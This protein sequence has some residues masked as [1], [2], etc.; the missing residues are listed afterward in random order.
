MAN[1]PLVYQLEIAGHV[2]PAREVRGREAMSDPFRF[3][4]QCYLPEHAKLDP[5][6]VVKSEV[7]LV[8]MREGAMRQVTAL[9][10]DAFVLDAVAGQ[11]ELTV[12]LEPRFALL[13]YKSNIKIFRDKGVQ[14]IVSEVLDESGVAHEWRLSSGYPVRP[15][16][17]QH[18]ETDRH[19]VARM[20]EEE[21]IFYF[22]TEQGVM[23]L[24]DSPAAYDDVGAVPFL[25]AG[26]MDRNDEGVAAM[27]PTAAASVGQVTLRDW[28]SDTPS[29]NMDV[30]ASGPTPAGPEFYDFPGEYLEPGEGQRLA[31]LMADAYEC[32]ANGFAGTSYVGA[33][34]PGRTF[35]LDHPPAGVPEGR[36][37]LTAVE[38]DWHRE[39][40]GF[41]VTFDAL[42]GARTFRPP[43]SHPEPILPNPVTGIVTGP[44]GE[45]DIYTDER[46]RVKVHFHWDRLLP[47]DGECSDWVPVLQDNTGESVA[48]P[49]IGWEVLVHY[50]EGDPDR[51]VVLGRVY[52]AEDQ[53]PAL[54]PRDKT[55]TSLKSY[56]SPTRDGI[57]MIEF[58]DLAGREYVYTHAEKD[59]NIV[60][61]NDK[62]EDILVSEKTKVNHDETIQI[63]NNTTIKIDRHTTT[64]VRAN[65]T[66]SVGGNQSLDSGANDNNTIEGNRALSVGGSYHRRLGQIETTQV[67]QTLTE[68]VGGAILETSLSTNGNIGGLVYA[69]TVGGAI[70]EIAGKQK[71]ESAAKA[72]VE[73]IGGVV[74]SSVDG[75]WKTEVG[76][77][78][79]TNVGAIKNVTAAKEL[80]LTGKEKF[81]AVSAI[82]QYQS[83]QEL[84]FKVGETELCMKDGLIKINAPETVAMKI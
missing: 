67:S 83:E 57:N 47:C 25:N 22:F 68:Q 63:G 42:D 46:G 19:F 20:L 17:V 82:G 14:T 2:L 8:L 13:R 12:V 48:H 45:D 65:Q 70:V 55:R 15:Y 7:Q 58:Q 56:S 18:R 35:D 29:L 39:Q 59:Q 81:S 32:Q 74:F 75:E 66:W 30:Q 60:V 73:T 72:R 38:H 69:L 28:N 40:T 78:R 84:T 80:T 36:Y 49:R 5:D 4:V 79:F 76:K 50:L 52:N 77:N 64:Q 11:P 1:Q 43:R 33:F 6:S 21:G 31:S 23:V 41:D 62:T 61:A 44:P 53:F 71:G 51:P 27:G 16:C 37:V 9:V 24:G 34:V 54:L 10:S 3:E 26:G